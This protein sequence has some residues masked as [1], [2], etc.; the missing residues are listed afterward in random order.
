MKNR[1][2]LIVLLVALG[3]GLAAAYLS[4]D[5]LRQQ[6]T[7]LIAATPKARVVVAARP[8]PLGHEIVAEDLKTI[9]WPGATVPEGYFEAPEQV[10]GR[11]VITPVAMNEPVL[12]PKVA[13]KEA[14]GGLPIVIP[15]GM[16]AVSV[17]V[18]EVISV[19]GFVVPRTR[20]DVIVTLPLP[21]NSSE[22]R[23]QFVQRLQDLMVLTAAQTTQPTPDGKPQTVSVMTFLVTPAQAELLILASREGQIQ[24]ALRNTLDSDTIQ[25]SGVLSNAILGAP[26]RSAPRRRAR[27]SA[28][29]Q[30]STSSVIEVYKGGAR[31]LIRH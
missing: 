7:P 29:T 20:V 9:D 8:L 16:R 6:A 1:R 22:R 31:T 28:P 27:A 12:K 25:T 4:L 21:G 18:D 26:P 24:L 19:A 5:Y 15:P 3:A 14:G 17:R 2:L 11:G 13:D 10:I 23:T 30:E